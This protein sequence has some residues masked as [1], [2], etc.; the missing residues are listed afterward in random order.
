MNRRGASHAARPADGGRAYSWAALAS[1]SDSDSVASGPAVTPAKPQGKK[2]LVAPGAPLKASK[3]TL[4]RLMDPLAF[5]DTPLHGP[6]P[7]SEAGSVVVK[8]VGTWK[9]HPVLEVRCALPPAPA[10]SSADLER[11]LAELLAADP[12]MVALNTPGV[13]WGDL[14]AGPVTPATVSVEPEER[15]LRGTSSEF[16]AQ[17]FTDNL[18]EY[19]ADVYDTRRLTDEEWNAMMSWLYWKGWWIGDY[20]REWISAEPDDLPA[21]RWCAPPAGWNGFDTLDSDDFEEEPVKPARVKVVRWDDAPA[22]EGGCCGEAPKAPKKKALR[23]AGLAP[24]PVMRFCRA[25]ADC[26]EKDTGCRYVH[27]DTIPKIDKPCGFGAE[28]GASD[29]TGLKR[30]QCIYMHPGEE[31]TA[32]LCIHRP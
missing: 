2:V 26:P 6:L 29:P 12:E 21:R 3:T 27:G 22:A 13:C 1:D 10:P 20:T 32:D 31:W 14:F 19:T 4:D 8:E 28:C 17:P 16:W 11:R 18:D 15:P 30:S 9:G 23:A 25:G 7:P 5:R 24:V